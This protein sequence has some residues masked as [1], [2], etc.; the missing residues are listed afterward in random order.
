MVQGHL[1]LTLQ[2]G[3]EKHLFPVEEVQPFLGFL[4]DCLHKMLYI[5]IGFCTYLASSTLF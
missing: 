2:M 4:S 3:K 5:D 1:A